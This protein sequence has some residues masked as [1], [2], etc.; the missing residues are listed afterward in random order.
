MRAANDVCLRTTEPLPVAYEHNEP[1]GSKTGSISM[2][3]DVNALTNKPCRGTQGQ[4]VALT[5]L[6]H[7][8]GKKCDYFVVYI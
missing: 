5:C 4:R 8:A 3:T 2:R 6:Y 7:I 1:N